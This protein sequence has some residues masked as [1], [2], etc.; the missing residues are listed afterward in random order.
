MTLSE[1]FDPN[2]LPDAGVHLAL[3]I[4]I[5]EATPQRVVVTVPVTSKVTGARAAL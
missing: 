2:H 3:G 5:T 4:T 1:S